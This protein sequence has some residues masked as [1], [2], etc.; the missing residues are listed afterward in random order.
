MPGELNQK[1]PT[2]TFDTSCI[3]PHEDT[4]SP[5]AIRELEM[6]HVE[7]R[8]EIVKADVLDTE[9]GE[10]NERLREKSEKYPEDLGVAVYGHSR[11]GHAVYAG[12]EVD[13]PFEQIRDLLFPSF[14]KMSKESQDRAVRDAMHLATHRMHK[15]DFFVTRD[16]HHM[17]SHSKDLEEKFGIV[18]VTPDECVR[19]LR[20]V[21]NS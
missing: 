2:I 5:A 13:Y 12:P 8:I 16:E 19:R 11:Y 17:I 10:R 6:M 18:V 15:R 14:A 7:G 3:Y 4:S 9:L 21:S 20:S 1:R